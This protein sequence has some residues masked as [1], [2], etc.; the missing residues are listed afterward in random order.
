MLSLAELATLRQAMR[1]QRADLTAASQRNHAR[2]A[3]EQFETEFADRLQRNTPKKIALYSAFSGELNPEPL[4]QCPCLSDAIFYLPIL[5][6]QSLRF[7][8]INSQPMRKNRFGI[9]E[10]NVSVELQHS[11]DELD[12]IVVPLLAVDNSGNRL[13][14]GGGFYDRALANSNPDK[15]DGKPL[16]LGYAHDF[17]RVAALPAQIWDVPLHGIVTERLARLFRGDLSV[18]LSSVN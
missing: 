14:M 18:Q 2:L 1:Q 6:G 15:Q 13:G 16:L 17:Q 4:R 12:I 9:D 5:C 10:P 3:A 8:Q 7:G 11:A